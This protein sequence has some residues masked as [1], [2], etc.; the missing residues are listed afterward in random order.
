MAGEK[1][2]STSVVVLSYKIV[3]LKFPGIEPLTLHIEPLNL[4]IRVNLHSN[5]LPHKVEVP[6]PYFFKKYA[7]F[8]S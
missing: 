5:M 6:L 7:I 3:T 4:H 2:L 8:T 1:M